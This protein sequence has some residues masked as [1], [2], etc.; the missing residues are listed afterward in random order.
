VQGEV[1]LLR[2]KHKMQRAKHNLRRSTPSYTY[3]LLSAC[4]LHTRRCRLIVVNCHM[5]AG[6]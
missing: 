1:V 2:W 4:A 3:I 5:G 6:N